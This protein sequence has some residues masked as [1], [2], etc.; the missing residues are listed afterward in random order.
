MWFQSA[1]GQYTYNIDDCDYFSTRMCEP[2]SNVCAFGKITVK[3]QQQQQQQNQINEDFMMPAPLHFSYFDFYFQAHANNRKMCFGV[4]WYD[5]LLLLLLLLPLS[6]M[7]ETYCHRMLN[8]ILENSSTR[9]FYATGKCYT[10]A[11]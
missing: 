5:V 9:I 7:T 1:F 10:Y 4:Y 2:S 3:Q 11:I 8:Y 6:A